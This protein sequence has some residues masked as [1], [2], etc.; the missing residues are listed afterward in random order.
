MALRSRRRF[1]GTASTAGI[2]AIAGCSM[3]GT[4]LF[5][6]STTAE[7][8]TDPLP[9]ESAGWPQ[10]GRNPRHTG[11]TPEVRID[12]PSEDWTFG[13]AGSMAP[14]A[15]VGDRVVVHGGAESGS[16]DEGGTGPAVFSLRADDGSE[17]WRRN[18]PHFGTG[19]SG[20]PPI[21][22]RGSVYVGHAGESGVYAIDAREGTPR[23]RHETDDS[24]NEAPVAFDAVAADGRLYVPCYWS[25][26]DEGGTLVALSD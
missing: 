18:L 6:W 16:D 1:L 8:A 24:V 11:F 12:D 21:V 4:S 3:T 9:G 26:R 19:Y 10:Y 20:C 7:D 14:P 23:W 13:L 15:V 25:S 17:Q 22:Y 2:V 5:D